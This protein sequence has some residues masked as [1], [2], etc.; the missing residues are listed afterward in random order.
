MTADALLDRYGVTMTPAD[1]SEVLHCH[2][3]HVRALCRSGEL[4]GVRVGDRWLVP[5]SKLAIIIDGGDDE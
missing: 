5:T 1:V 2:P 3:S 4:P